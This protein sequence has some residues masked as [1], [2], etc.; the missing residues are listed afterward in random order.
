MT[1]VLAAHFLAG[2]LLTLLLPLGLL[3]IVV[4]AW[5]VL[6]RREARRRAD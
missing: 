1:P 5:S 4:V 6:L 3:V 2:S